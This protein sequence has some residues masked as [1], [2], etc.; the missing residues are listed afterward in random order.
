MRK[1]RFRIIHYECGDKSFYDTKVKTL[2]GWI[3]FSVFFKTE[4]IHVI[5]DPS[6]QKSLALERIYEYCDVKG[7]KRQD[8]F[9]TEINVSRKKKWIFF[10]RILTK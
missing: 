10:Q 4:L 7:Y 3:S 2:F 8:V 1:R 6:V 5:S 9:I